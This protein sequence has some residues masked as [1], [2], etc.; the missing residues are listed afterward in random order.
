ME[1]VLVAVAVVVVSV[2]LSK[3]IK[4]LLVT[5]P[6]KLKLPPGPW[7]L[8]LIGSMHHLIRNPLPHRAMRDLA[9]KHGPLMMLWLGELPTVV[10]IRE[11]VARFMQSLATSAAGGTVVDLSKMIS[12][13]VNDTF[14]MES[15]GS[16]C[17]YQDEYLDA[18]GTAIELIT[19]LS[20][21]N[22][23]PSSRLLQNLST[24]PRRAMACRDRMT[25]IVGQI[26]R[27]MKEGMDRGDKASNESLISVLLSLQKEASLPIEL[28][29]DIVMGLMIELFGAGSDTSSTTLT[30]CMT[31]LIRYPATM[32]RAQ[33]EVREAFKGKTTTITEDDLARA[34]H[35][36]LKCVVKEALRL[37]CP[38]PLIQRRCRETCQVMGYDIPKGTWVFLHVWAI[39]RDAK[40]W[41][42][43][44]EFKPERFENTNRDY[45]GRDYEFL[46]FGSDR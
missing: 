28:T 42:D 10:R 11:E 31:E 5:K 12:S 29:D 15:I 13:F 30:W 27:E 23:F 3:L 41:E 22:I 43:A 8:P 46:P 44:E 40:Y 1:K 16:R 25:R 24:V 20:V 38:L 7:R 14:V 4:C 35:S 45:K 18:L 39:C 2:I 34:N 33:A 6:K 36:Y 9:H 32:A 17:K 19:E 37:H 21:A 26:I